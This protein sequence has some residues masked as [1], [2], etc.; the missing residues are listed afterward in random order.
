MLAIADVIRLRL[1][2]YS[3][4]FARICLFVQCGA[5]SIQ[6]NE[7]FTA[8][9]SLCTRNTVSRIWRNTSGGHT[10]YIVYR[11]WRVR[12][13][14]ASCV[15]FFFHFISIFTRKI[16]GMWK[17]NVSHIEHGFGPFHIAHIHTFPILWGN[18]IEFVLANWI[19][20]RPSSSLPI[21][22][23]RNEMNV[24]QKIKIFCRWSCSEAKRYSQP[25]KVFA[26]TQLNP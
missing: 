4:F 9:H 21:Q 1:F 26:G 10:V 22:G 24:Y 12:M 6:V 20:M 13:D 11:A 25:V 8:P 17:I 23:N 14:A 18:I 15:C 16:N 7:S 5:A 3:L 2:I 19:Y